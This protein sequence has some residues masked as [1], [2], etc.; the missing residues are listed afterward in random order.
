MS[1]SNRE[2]QLSKTCQLYT[3][4]LTAQDKEV[5]QHIQECAEYNPSDEYDCLVDC[6]KELSVEVKSFNS[7]TF[8]R[9]VDNKESIEAQKLSQ[10][11]EM[12]QMY[13]PIEND[14]D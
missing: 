11:W 5:P 2:I 10:W 4:V 8:E 13:I 3:Y 7:D 9:I 14:A 12:Y 6:Q 1:L